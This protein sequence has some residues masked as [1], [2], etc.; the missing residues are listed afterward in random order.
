MRPAQE[1]QVVEAGVA[2][3]GPVD[4]VV[5][6]AGQ[7]HPV[8][9]REA[10]VGVAQHEGFPDRSGD[11]ALGAADVED[12]VEG[13]EH[14]GDDFGVAG[15]TADAGVAFQAFPGHPALTGCGLEE[16]GP[17][18]DQLLPPPPLR[19]PGRTNGPLG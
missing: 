4:E 7:R 15:E 5:G 10:A 14:G 6:V 2:A 16:V 19:S 12:L 8:A 13:P 3:V 9:A 1:H 11:Q 18:S 17:P